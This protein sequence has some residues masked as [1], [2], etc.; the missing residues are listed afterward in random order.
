MRAPAIAL[1][2]HDIAPPSSRSRTV[3]LTPTWCQPVPYP[4][5]TPP[6]LRPSCSSNTSR[7]KSIVLAQHDFI[8]VR[9]R[10]LSHHVQHG[11]PAELLGS[12]DRA[13]ILLSVF[14]GASPVPTIKSGGI[15]RYRIPRGGGAAIESRDVLLIPEDLEDLRERRV[16]SGETSR[17]GIFLR[18][19]LLG[20]A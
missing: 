3:R 17:S 5:D 4:R 18:R 8:S 1:G 9:E 12:T 16:P 10:S 14:S 7:L 15:N 13:G 20:D 11:L 2:S 19:R 6:N